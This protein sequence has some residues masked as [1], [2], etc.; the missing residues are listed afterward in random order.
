MTQELFKK[1]REMKLLLGEYVIFG[2]GPM[3]I[4]DLRE[5]RDLDILVT[6][7]IFEGYKKK[8]DW[9]LVEF[10]R[11]GRQVEFLEKENIEL[12]KEW[13]P[14][15][16]NNEKLIKEAELI[17]GLPFVKLEYFIK[18]KKISGREKDLND[19]KLI[20]EYLKNRFKENKNK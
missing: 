4:L 14:G 6:K 2:S 17:D 10:E 1:V 7:D 18:W 19:I 12:Y 9:K 5:C 13:G 20:K 11:D 16:W 3:C 15:E 8:L